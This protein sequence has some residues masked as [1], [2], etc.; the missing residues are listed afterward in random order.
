MKKLI[1]GR[2]AFVGLSLYALALGAGCKGSPEVYDEK[3]GDVRA[4]AYAA[5]VADGGDRDG[6]DEGTRIGE[7]VAARAIDGRLT[8]V[9]QGEMNVSS[10]TVYAP[11]FYMSAGQDSE[12]FEGATDACA[13]AATDHKVECH[14]EADGLARARVCEPGEKIVDSAR[15]ARCETG[16]RAYFEAL[17]RSCGADAESLKD[18]KGASCEMG[19]QP[20]KKPAAPAPAEDPFKCHAMSARLC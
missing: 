11:D 9:T 17:I 15:Q 20:I 8:T 12:G 16:A 19:R 2:I 1:E 3:L 5:C 10:G 18:G 7:I 4:E 14:M 13:K 6:C